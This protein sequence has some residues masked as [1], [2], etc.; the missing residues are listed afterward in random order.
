MDVFIEAVVSVL[1]PALL[2]IGEGNLAALDSIAQV[3]LSLELGTV[4]QW[5]TA[6]LSYLTWKTM[7]PRK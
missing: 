5:V 1:I 7:R 2:H 6:H 3:P 4:S